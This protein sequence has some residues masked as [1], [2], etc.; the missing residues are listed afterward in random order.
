MQMAL[1]V[2]FSGELGGREVS[3]LLHDELGQSLPDWLGGHT[4]A[5]VAKQPVAGFDG[6][7]P[8]V[9]AESDRAMG[10]RTGGQCFAP[11]SPLKEA[12]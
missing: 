1:H 6:R 11:V 8:P 10:L 12:A 3:Q 9:N 4:S 2:S 5:H 7:D